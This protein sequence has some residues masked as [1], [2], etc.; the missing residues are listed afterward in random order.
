MTTYQGHHLREVISVR[1]V[2]A[3][4][5]LPEEKWHLLW[6]CINNAEHHFVAICYDEEEE[7]SLDVLN[8][9]L[10]HLNFATA[11]RNR[12]DNYLSQRRWFSSFLNEVV[13][14][15]HAQ[16]RTGTTSQLILHLQFS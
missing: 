2:Q 15:I 11:N 6:E 8:T 5:I 16:G 1:A 14:S 12:E 13:F 4:F 9:S 10:V 7:H 3:I